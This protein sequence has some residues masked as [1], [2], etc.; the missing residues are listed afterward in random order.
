[1][2]KYKNLTVT[3]LKVVV[4][5]ML[6]VGL[7]ACGFKLRGAYTLPEAIQ[8]IYVQGSSGSDL[9]ADLKATLAYSAQVVTKKIDADAI[10]VINKEDVKRRTLSV[11]SRGKVREAELEYTVLYS[12]VTPAGDVLLEQESVVLVRDYVDDE[13]DVIGRSNE[14]QIIT[15][16]LKRDASQRIVRRLQTLGTENK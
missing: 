16:D 13:N 5:S 12:V 9:V 8:K 3:T 11:D 14:A 7:T 4:L 2:K 6:L 1:M 15:K 10:L